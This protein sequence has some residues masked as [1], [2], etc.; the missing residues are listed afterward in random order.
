MYDSLQFEDGLTLYVGS[1]LVLTDTEVFPP[2]TLKGR[3]VKITSCDK[4]KNCPKSDDCRKVIF[5]VRESISFDPIK[6]CGR[7]HL[8]V[9]NLNGTLAT[10]LDEGLDLKDIFLVNKTKKMI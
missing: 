7:F 3:L 8:H 5:H 6:I 1:D 9:T 2:T 10:N 4:V